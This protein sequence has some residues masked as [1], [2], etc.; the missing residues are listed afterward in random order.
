MHTQHDHAERITAKNGHYILIVKGNQKNLRKQMKKLPRREIPLQ[1][2]TTDTG[3]GR[4]EIRRLKVCT[5]RPGLLLGSRDGVKLSL[6]GLSYDDA[7]QLAA[8]MS[9]L[10]SLDRGEVT[11]PGHDVRQVVIE[12]DG[13]YTYM[14]SSGGQMPASAGPAVVSRVRA[15]PVRV[16]L[17]AR[18]RDRPPW[19][20]A[21]ED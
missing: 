4:R 14:M 3:H 2:R 8:V 11:V 1:D 17:S 19:L 21:R 12:H 13:G 18:G 20:L 15:P 9:S 6:A 7:D 10:Y 16:A 5:V